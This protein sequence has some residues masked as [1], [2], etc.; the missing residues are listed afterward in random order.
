MKQMKKDLQGMLKSLKS[1]TVKVE[2]LIKKVETLGKPQKPKK[3]KTEAPS[4][5]RAPKTTS[6]S[7]KVLAIIRRYKKGVDGATLRKKT[8]FE[9]RKIRD[10]V[11]RLKKRD[12]IKTV[13][14]GLYL[15]A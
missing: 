12:K 6:D 3:P 7:D 15:K 1:A 9:G 2:K 8:G 14:K 10:I 13:G 11:Y 4:K 5:A